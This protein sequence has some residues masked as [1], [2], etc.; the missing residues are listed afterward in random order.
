MH[1]GVPIRERTLAEEHPLDIGHLTICAALVALTGCAGLNAPRN[2]PVEARRQASDIVGLIESG[3]ACF[4]GT[5]PELPP[6]A[7]L[8]HRGINPFGALMRLTEVSVERL[9]SR[10]FRA[11]EPPAW[12][13]AEIDASGSDVSAHVIRRF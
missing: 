1:R 13:H 2:G 7:S 3:P 10:T 12:R 11:A 5:S 4:R 6:G 8:E 9:R